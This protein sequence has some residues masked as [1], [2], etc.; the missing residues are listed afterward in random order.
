MGIL[1]TLLLATLWYSL[2]KQRGQ[3]PFFDIHRMVSRLEE[4]DTKV[5]WLRTKLLSFGRQ[6]NGKTDHDTLHNYANTV[7]N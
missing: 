6:V 2:Q 4:Y 7:A 5:C 3:D 1:F